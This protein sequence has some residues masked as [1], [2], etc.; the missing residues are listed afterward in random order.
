[1]AQK[2]PPTHDIR[3]VDFEDVQTFFDEIVKDPNLIHTEEL[4]FVK[5]FLENFNASIPKL[6]VERKEEKGN[7]DASE[8]A[9]PAP[10]E[11]EEESS[12]E[13][14][15]E[16]E[17]D[18]FTPELKEETEPFPAVAPDNQSPTDED[19]QKAGELKMQAND[20][21]SSGDLDKAIK[22]LTDAI[23]LA[24][25]PLTYGKRAEILLKSKRPG[26]AINDCT[27]ALSSNPDSCK[28]LKI[29]GQAYFKIGQYEKAAADLRK[30]MAIDF[31]PSLGDVMKQVNE[32][33]E[34][35]NS[36]NVRKRL[37]EEK[38]E[39]KRREKIIK[40]RKAAQK[41][42]AEEAKKQKASG[43]GGMPGGMPGGGMPGGGMG[44]G[45]IEQLL[46]M[47]CASDPALAAD[48]AKPNVKAAAKKIFSNPQM[49]SNP[50]ML[51]ELMKDPDVASFYTK[52]M[53][54][55]QGM[56]GGMGGMPGGGMGG[57][58]P[59][60]GMPGGGMPGGGTPFPG[61]FP[62]R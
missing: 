29:R 50:A 57:G 20:A 41:R 2:L 26:A 47:L 25:S 10:V 24:A 3:A 27:T 55:L 28:N 32:R 49:M 61:G 46:Q 23:Q 38:R 30:A 35:I 51:Q 16:E 4:K 40:E 34:K 8:D 7:V 11:E 15:E 62:G 59:F 6:K 58:M 36:R 31:D 33:M 45:Q 60:G 52:L 48:Y 17:D 19:R 12:A 21:K 18:D 1:M 56:M 5:T 39:R 44:G 43:G 54:K 53:P 22:L 14:D 13:E 9:K 42:A 37:K